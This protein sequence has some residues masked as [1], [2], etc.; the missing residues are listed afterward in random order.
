MPRL[1]FLGDRV[2]LLL[3]RLEDDVGLV[4]AKQRPMGRDQGHVEVVDLRELFRLGV[5]RT[6]HA[7]ELV[8]HAEIVLEG[9][10]R[11]GLALAPDLDAFLRFDRLMQTVRPASPRHEATRVLVDDHDFL[12]AVVAHAHDVVDVEALQR[13]RHQRLLQRMQH[14]QHLRVVEVVDPQHLLDLGHALVGEGGRMG[15]LVEPEIAGLFDALRGLGGRAGLEGRDQP[16]RDRVDLRV[17][18][19]RPRD[20][21][22]RPGL[23]DQDR[24]DLVDD[25]EMQVPLDARLRLELHVVA[26]VVEAELVVRAVGDVGVVGGLALGVGKTMHD[27]ADLETEEAMEL[28]HPLGVATREEVVHGHDVHAAAGEAV[29]VGRQGRDEGLA[30]AG[31]HLGDAPLMEH[32]P[33]D[34]LDVVVPLSEGALRGLAHRRKGLGQQVVEGLALLE[35]LAI[36]RRTPAEIRVG[37]LRELALE[38]VHPLDEGQQALDRPVI[39]RA[40]EF[41]ECS[42]HRAV[43]APSQ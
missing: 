2:E 32:D 21:E 39:A 11:E 29:Q 36:D 7:A 17:L 19:R 1:E 4:V 42:L 28:A 27:R 41:A 16:V 12:R 33:A 22:R 23:V 20:D 8:V 34:H 9:D 38:D 25:R 26:Q 30:L 5:R 31:L 18:L 43:P 3:L 14:G 35:P 10:R 37:E 40:E 13:V 24:I 6:G 15:L